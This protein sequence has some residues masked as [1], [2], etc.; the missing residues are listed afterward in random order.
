[1]RSGSAVVLAKEEVAKEGRWAD[2]GAAVGVG[3]G[4][5]SVCVPS[6]I[7]H[8]FFLNIGFI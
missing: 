4:R 8:V 5:C 7:Q 2:S 1:M 3:G 6:T